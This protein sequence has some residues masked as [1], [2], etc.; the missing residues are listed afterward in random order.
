MIQT[1]SLSFLILSLM[2]S[3]ISISTANSNV[4][5][6]CSQLNFTSVTPYD[7]NVNSLF[8][9]LVDSA[10]ICNFNK[11][12][13]APLN[14]VVYG[15]YQ[16]RGDL[17]SPNCKDCVSNSISQLKTICPM[18]RGGAIQ[19][20]ECFV[21]YNEASFFE[22]DDK[23]EVYKRCGPS[24]GYNYDVLNNIDGVLAYLVYGNGQY[25][26]QYDFA[27][28]QGV[29]QCVQDLSLSD[30]QDCLSEASRQLRSECETST[31]GDMYLGKC[32]IRYADHG[33]ENHANDGF[34]AIVGVGSL[35][36]SVKNYCTINVIN[37]G[38]EKMKKYVEGAKK[39]VELVKSDAKSAKE[40]AQKAEIEAK[41][42]KEKAQKAE[43]EAN[44]AK[45]KT[46]KTEKIVGE[47]IAKNGFKL[48]ISYE[49][50]ISMPPP[51]YYVSHSSP[52]YW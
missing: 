40:K 51:C 48:Y 23:M 9:S 4:Y 47:E 29:A 12:E 13:I 26:R 42:A 19:L 7:S 43:T 32:Y 11:F 37:K 36:F 10:S 50:Q 5:V 20:E 14:D 2:F 38:M 39:D 8:T 41:S 27:T 28:I 45:E 30:C 31:W 15:L 49:P 3:I 34:V 6:Q 17:S 52:C 24:V 21:K 33:N 44:S 25:F 16:C 35:T 22:E 1:L 46:D 18:S